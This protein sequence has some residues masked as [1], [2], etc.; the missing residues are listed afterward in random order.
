MRILILEDMEVRKNAFL[1]ALVKHGISARVCQT[2]DDCVESLEK[3]SW[4]WITLD[5]D[6][7]VPEEHARESGY[8]VAKWLEEHPEKCPAKVLIHSA[9]TGG[10]RNM[11]VALPNAILAPN[12][13]EYLDEVLNL[14]KI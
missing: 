7:V 9:N 6:V 8:D 4:D 1:S 11:K 10:V 2:A 12:L 14:L 13:W 5:H 3:E